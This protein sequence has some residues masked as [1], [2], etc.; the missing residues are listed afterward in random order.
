MERAFDR[1]SEAGD[2]HPLDGFEGF[3][4]FIHARAPR[5]TRSVVNQ[6]GILFR[7]FSHAPIIVRPGL[8]S[9]GAECRMP[10]CMDKF[11]ALFAQG[12]LSL[13]R[14]RS[15]VLV[16]EAGGLA[17]AVE[18]DEARASLLSR[19][20]RELES[21][22]G[23]ALT[24]RRGKGIAFTAAGEELAQL[25]RQHLQAL[26]DFRRACR[27]EPRIV[28]L[29]AGNSILEWLLVPLL[30]ALRAKLPGVEFELLDMRTRDAA[31]QLTRLTADL[32]ILRADAV[33]AG[34]ASLP[35]RPIGFALFVPRALAVGLTPANLRRRFSSLPIAAPIG[36]QF[37]DDF[38]AAAARAGWRLQRALTCSTITH[39]A[40]AVRSGSFAAILP[41]TA[42]VDLDP[43]QIQ[44]FTLPFFRDYRRPLCLVWNVRAA[45]T[46]PLVRQTV[47]ALAPLLAPAVRRPAA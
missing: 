12:G 41:E 33:T 13:D 17:R 42:V 47:E 21:F 5:G 46:R 30:A 22:F 15:F 23:V 1:A 31:L 16:V 36:G 7:I 8:A 39:A 14:L 32:G 4:Q 44:R 26:D 18:G 2:T 9:H 35:V 29:V 43:A 6:G 19:Q 24:R 27:A 25:A 10:D 20:I 34:L 28:R 38:E 37:R 40:R 45:E 11:S 3:S